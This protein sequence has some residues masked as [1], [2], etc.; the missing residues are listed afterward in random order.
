MEWTK[1]RRVKKA[2][3][4]L[5]KLSTPL[6][7]EGY[8][9]YTSLS[10]GISIFPS[11]GQTAETLL[12]NADIA[13][14]QVK[15]Q[16]RNSFRFF[17]PDMNKR[18]I[19]RLEMENNLRYAI[20]R[21]ELFLEYQPQ[22]NVQNRQ[23]F[24]VESLIR[25]QQPELG[26]IRPDQF[27]RMAEETGLI[28]PIGNWVMKEAF[29]QN[30]KWSRD[31]NANITTAVNISALQFMQKS[32]VD[33]VKELID[34]TGVNP[35]NIELELTES[36][37]MESGQ[38][39]DTTLEKLKSIGLQL[40]IDDFGTGYSSLSYLKHLPIDRLKV[41]RSFIK[42]ME[43]DTD[44]TAITNAIIAMAKSLKL[45]VIAEGV[46]NKAQL[47]ILQDLGCNEIQGYL[48]GKPERPEYVESRFN[49]TY[50]I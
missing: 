39:T 21:G 11:D 20:E 35:K 13:M 2:N 32:F 50:D 23:L 48:F 12:K 37:L 38:K 9:I 8:E 7:V 30:V 19:K 28:L 47:G 24:G 41:D 17:S 14:Y 26:L 34:V 15:A 43:E 46:E 40:A 27:I 33:E 1:Y 49:T 4:L 18:S 16:G 5:Q 44:S 36:L 31:L 22:V 29:T 3:D 42:D 10:I 25:W 6:F 45:H